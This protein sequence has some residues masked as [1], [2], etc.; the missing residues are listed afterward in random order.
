MSR[1][2]RRQSPLRQTG[3]EDRL[4]DPGALTTPAGSFD[5]LSKGRGDRLALDR[6]G[7]SAQHQELAP[8]VKAGKRIHVEGTVARRPHP[9]AY[10]TIRR[11]IQRHFWR[12]SCGFVAAP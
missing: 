9:D 3:C 12:G 10:W 1:E 6:P 7:R 11:P 4:C 2:I 5:N 8:R